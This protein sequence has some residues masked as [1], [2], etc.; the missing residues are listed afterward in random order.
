MDAL[1]DICRHVLPNAFFRL[2]SLTLY[3]GR[4]DDPPLAVIECPFVETRMI[5]ALKSFPRY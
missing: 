3:N 4:L 5:E 2:D 1:V